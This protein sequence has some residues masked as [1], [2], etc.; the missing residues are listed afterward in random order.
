MRDFSLSRKPV[1]DL[2]LRMGR[3]Q[4]EVELPDYAI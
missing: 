2:M 4:A 3:D 1:M